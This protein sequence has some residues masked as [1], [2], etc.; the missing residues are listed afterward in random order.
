MPGEDMDV[1]HSFP[2]P[3]PHMPLPQLFW[4]HLLYKI[5]VNGSKMFT[6]FHESF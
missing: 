5:P 2:H 4:N 3:L 6:K 1:L